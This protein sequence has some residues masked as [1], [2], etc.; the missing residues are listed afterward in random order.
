MLSRF[1]ELHSCYAVPRRLYFIV[2]ASPKFP[3]NIA[4]DTANGWNSTS[5]AVAS[6][7]HS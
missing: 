6:A 5:L 7:A 4:D 2:N 3:I 1:S